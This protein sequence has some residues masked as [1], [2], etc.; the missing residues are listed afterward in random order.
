[1]QAQTRTDMLELQALRPEEDPL[2]DLTPSRAGD[3]TRLS[4][5][6]IL[7]R[8]LAINPAADVGY[9]SGFRPGMLVDYLDHLIATSQPRGREARWQRRGDTPAILMR[10][11]EE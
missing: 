5:P 9:L 11:P 6:Q 3:E 4:H 1:M 7:E 2:F 10:E 8:I